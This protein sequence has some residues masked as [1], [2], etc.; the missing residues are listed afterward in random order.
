MAEAPAIVD[1]AIVGRL[2]VVFRKNGYARFRTSITGTNS[3]A[4]AR[5]DTRHVVAATRTVLRDTQRLPRAAGFN[6]GRP[7][8]KGAGWRQLIYWRKE[9]AR[10]LDPVG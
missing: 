5:R 3:L 1:A 7:F 8:A 2:T 9:V 10:F 6:P 4:P